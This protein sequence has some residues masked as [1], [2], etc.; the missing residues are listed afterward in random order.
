MEILKSCFVILFCSL[1]VCIFVVYGGN[2]HSVTQSAHLDHYYLLQ[3]S[4]SAH[5]NH[6]NLIDFELHLNCLFFFFFF[7]DCILIALFYSW[8]FP[9]SVKH[10]ELPGV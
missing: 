8:C 10:W 5:F 2:V 7:I 4:Y 6:I 9:A 1:L 3:F